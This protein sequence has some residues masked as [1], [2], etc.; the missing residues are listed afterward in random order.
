MGVA[1]PIHFDV[2]RDGSQYFSRA[3]GGQKFAIARQVLYQGNRGLANDNSPLGKQ[4]NYDAANF[5]ATF[6]FWADFIAPTAACEGRSFLTLN[7][8]D[9]ARFTYGFTQF[10]AHVANG[11]FVVWFRAMLGLPEASDYFPDLSV[12]SG[13]IVKEGAFNDT[14]LETD[15]TTGALMDYLNPTPGTVDDEEVIAAAKFIHWNMTHPASQALQVSQMVATGHAIL[16][17]A[18]TRLGLDGVSADLCCIV[19]DIL[20]Q[21]RGTFA[22]MLQALQQSDP[23]KALLTIGSPVYDERIKTLTKELNAR[24]PAFAQKKWKRSQA[25]FV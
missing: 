15:T 10:A 23:Y 13:H 5:T 6:D 22:Q 17:R 25:E 4:F 24:R 20:H 11:D 18:D 21:G 12:Q 16:K 2:I 1:M 19:M 14:P 9:R 8:Y 7:T 3:D